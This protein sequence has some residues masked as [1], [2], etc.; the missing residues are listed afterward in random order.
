ME[1]PLLAGLSLRRRWLM[2]LK[3]SFPREPIARQRIAGVR[4]A[5][6]RL[7]KHGYRIDLDQIFGRGHL[8]HLDH[9]RGGR[10]GPEI[11]AS[12]FMNQVEV[13]HVA[14]VNVDPADV[15]EGAAGL[16]DRGLEVLAD[17]ARL[18]LDVADTGDAAVGP[19]RGHARNEHK[20]ARGNADRVREMTA[21]LANL[22]GDDL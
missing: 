11:F 10:G 2:S 3:H 16:L 20:F 8:R 6:S 12:Y 17:L 19:A 1:P 9:G 15:V 18:R 21:R 7:R 13:L 22:F 5:K 14:H 4:G